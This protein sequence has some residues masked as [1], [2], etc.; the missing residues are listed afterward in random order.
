ML[1]LIA[2]GDLDRRADLLE[3]CLGFILGERAAELGLFVFELGLEVG[4]ELGEDVVLPLPGQVLSLRLGGSD[5]EVP[6]R[7]PFGYKLL[8]F[9]YKMLLIEVL[10]ACHSWSNWAKICSPSL[11]RR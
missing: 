7:R 1:R 2:R 10:M 6:W 8:F 11:E 5:L 3:P 9:S 4:A